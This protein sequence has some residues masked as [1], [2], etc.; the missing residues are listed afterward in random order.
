[1]KQYARYN[2]EEYCV[3]TMQL[4]AVRQQDLVPVLKKRQ[5]SMYSVPAV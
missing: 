2:N 5:Y 4:V 1:L 3:H